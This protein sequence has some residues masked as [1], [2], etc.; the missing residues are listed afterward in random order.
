M[1]THTEILKDEFTEKGPEIKWQMCRRC[2]LKRKRFDARVLGYPIGWL[3]G[4][5]DTQSCYGCWMN[6]I[7]YFNQHIA[8]AVSDAR[9]T[10]SDDKTE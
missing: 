3:D 5:A 2:Q 6:D 9:K 7:G 4:D 10:E 8:E 1:L